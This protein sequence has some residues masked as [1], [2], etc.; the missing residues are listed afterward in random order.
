MAQ[1][2]TLPPNIDLQLMQ[3][4]KNL[5]AE[6]AQRSKNEQALYNAWV[7][8]EKDKK[9]LEKIITTLQNEVATL[10]LQITDLGR[11]EHDIALNDMDEDDPAPESEWTR[12]EQGK[13]KRRLV[14]AP[15]P[16]NKPNNPLPIPSKKGSEKE[17]S[18]PIQPYQQ[19]KNRPPPIV[20]ENILNY[21][22][23]LNALSVLNIPP[24]GFLS[25]LLSNNRVKINATT[26]DTYRA[27][28]ALLNNKG[29]QWHS[30]EDKQNRDI[31][32][33]IKGLH[34]SIDPTDIV[35]C[36]NQL[37]LKAKNA[38]NKQKWLSVEQKQE[39]KANGLQD[40]VPLDMFIVSFDKDTNL[41]KIYN[42]KTIL[43]SKVQIEP[44]RKTNLIPQ[45][46]RCQD[47][48]HTHNYCHKTSRCVKCGKQHPTQDCSKPAHESPKC[49]HCG[50]NHPANYR[51]CAVYKDLLKL[52]STPAKS[53]PPP[54]RSTPQTHSSFS[55]RPAQTRM[56]T[57]PPTIS[58]DPTAP[59]QEQRTFSQAVRGP[60]N[61][62]IDSL[63]QQILHRLNS[64]EARIH[65]A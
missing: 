51:G 23:M 37:G 33:M 7:Q 45:C 55:P 42:T 29:M 64:L 36:L 27:I 60:Q 63:L 31:R 15:L 25:K 46:K 28:T 26:A 44:L 30:Y 65:H 43:N 1:P 38:I 56:S 11:T 18:S 17:P 24:G 9:N 48:G 14:E 58:I 22:Q 19:T 32:V 41:D 10:K 4:I 2:H 21:P 40:V 62:S 53:Q 20:I 3:E 13:R 57:A 39:R 54:E 50:D 6:N 52:R 16:T 47:Y 12:V 59:Y 35:S 8:S 34:H 61:T 5:F 49:V